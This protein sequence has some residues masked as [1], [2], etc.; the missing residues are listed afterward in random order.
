MSLQRGTLVQINNH[1]EEGCV[2]SRDCSRLSWEGCLNLH[3]L[4]SK[5][6]APRTK[7]DPLTEATA[8]PG[9]GSGIDP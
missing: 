4:S 6:P 3:T 2:P 9:V 1:G 5:M 8:E 7:G